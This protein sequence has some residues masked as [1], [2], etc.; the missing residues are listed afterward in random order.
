MCKFS[1]SCAKFFFDRKKPKSL[2]KEKTE[3]E[4]GKISG[5]H[6]NI[7]YDSD[8]ETHRERI[9]KVEEEEEA[10]QKVHL[11]CPISLIN[12]GRCSRDDFESM[13]FPFDSKPFDESIFVYIPT[14]SL[15]TDKSL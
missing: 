12:E 9:E 2:V 10:F 8:F 1:S 3:R 14:K 6:K 15:L 13:P 7:D 11:F 5:K 4:R